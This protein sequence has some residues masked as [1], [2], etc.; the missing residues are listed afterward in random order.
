MHIAEMHIILT[1]FSITKNHI[2]DHERIDRNKNFNIKF[3]I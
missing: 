1:L 3:L 2:K